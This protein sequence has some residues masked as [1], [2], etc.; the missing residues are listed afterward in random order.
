[1]ETLNRVFDDILSSK[2]KLSF[3]DEELTTAIEEQLK[4]VLVQITTTS[5]H[6]L[7][8]LSCFYM[9]KMTQAKTNEVQAVAFGVSGEKQRT[10]LGR[11]HLPAFGL[12]TDAFHKTIKKK[13]LL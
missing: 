4:K 11:V 1:M 13:L 9:L 2:A 6:L 12:A 7:L 8:G 10:H 3:T 5:D